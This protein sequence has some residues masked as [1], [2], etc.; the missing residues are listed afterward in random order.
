[1]TM[2]LLVVLHNLTQTE[3]NYTARDQEA[4]AVILMLKNINNPFAYIDF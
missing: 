1:M 2:D 3:R 4:R